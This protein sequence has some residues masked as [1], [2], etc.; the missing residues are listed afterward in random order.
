MSIDTKCSDTE[1]PAR[2]SRQDLANLTLPGI[3]SAITWKMQ[4]FISRTF[5]S[6]RLQACKKY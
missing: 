3:I 2:R 6:S 4:T 1:A 5:L